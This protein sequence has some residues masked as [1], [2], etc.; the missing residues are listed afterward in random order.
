MVESLMRIKLFTYS[1]STFPK[2]LLIANGKI[3]SLQGRKHENSHLNQGNKVSIT[4]DETNQ[5]PVPS[6]MMY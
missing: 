2:L 4:S 6:D 1:Q 5:Q 3:T